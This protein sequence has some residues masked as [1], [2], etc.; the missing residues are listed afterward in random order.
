[1]PMAPKSRRPGPDANARR[2]AERAADMA[3][4]IA[5]IQA[6]GAKTLQAIADGLN[7][8][9]IPTAA[10]SGKWSP[11]QVARVLQRI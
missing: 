11:V 4:L 6:S 8:R 3:P 9:R 1:M 5:E 10:G 7:E 2:A